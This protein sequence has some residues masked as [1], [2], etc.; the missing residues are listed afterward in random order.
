MPSVILQTSSNKTAEAVS[1]TDN[2]AAPVKGVYNLMTVTVDQRYIDNEA[3]YSYVL[4]AGT[5]TFADDKY[6][7]SRAYGNRDIIFNVMKQ[8][9]RKTTPI[10]I[11]AKVF[12]DTSLS[13]TSGQANQWTV[14]CTLLLPAIAAGVGVY[15]YAR[16]RYL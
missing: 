9:A 14:I 13:L 6:I 2:S 15:V 16:R 4:A 1:L 11:D 10:D 8:F 12:S 5:S 3:H 7:G